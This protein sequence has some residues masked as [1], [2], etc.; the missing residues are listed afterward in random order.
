[1]KPPYKLTSEGSVLYMTLDSPGSQVNIFTRAAA[2]QI[3][4]VFNTLD[5][6]KTNVVVFCSKKPYSYINGTQLVL[7]PSIKSFEDIVIL[8]EPTR[9]AY[10][11]ISNSPVITVAAIEG[12]CYGCGIEFTLCCD[13]RVAS[14]SSD[15][16]F[17]M[18]ELIDYHIPPVFGGLD[19]LPRLMGFK[20]AIDL[21][22]SGETW[23]GKDALDHR[24]VDHLFAADQF[25]E[26][27]TALLIRVVHEMDKFQ[28]PKIQV[29][30]TDL[31]IKNDILANINQLPLNRHKLHKGCI[32]IMYEVLAEDLSQAAIT[33]KLEHLFNSIP[34]SSWKNAS[35][36]FF[37]QAM[38]R[39]ASLGTSSL[40]PDQDV[41]ILLPPTPIVKP[42]QKI[43]LEKKIRGLNVQ[44][45]SADIADINE[46]S[47]LY[48]VA[49]DTRT[50][51]PV[52]VTWG[53]DRYKVFSEGICLYFPNK[54]SGLCEIWTT[55]T[56]CSFITPL[57]ILLFQLG[58][59]PLINKI[60]GESVLNR[61]IKTYTTLVQQI[62]KQK[63][64]LTDLYHT[65]WCFGFEKLPLD[66][67]RSLGIETQNQT[68]G[69]PSLGKELPLL[70][71]KLLLPLHEEG[72]QCIKEGRLKH[73][74]QVD[75]I[76]KQ[77][78]GFPVS[79]G[80]FSKYIKSIAI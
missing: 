13:I 33:V 72:R 36:F 32:E 17:F 30:E 20:S 69:D 80:N 9:L 4:E 23:S 5:T 53:Y 34:D 35:T 18:T 67:G 42:F 57:A 47:D 55:E 66:V 54:E 56:T 77:L 79:H 75:L 51:H 11:M 78:F 19:R 70:L 8:T 46:T 3:I 40:I 64:N 74:S 7:A 26:E 27:L 21:V 24:L 2:E 1:M 73:T 52:D 6:D 43:L 37:F 48:L 28:R 29:N 65:L 58:W 44:Q 25:S 10:G 49:P 71:E 39:T 22:H 76:L 14:D 62:G 68:F 41:E 60:P 45:A 16:K 63:E 61:F 38:A 59:E 50:Y 15:T 12:C 31:L